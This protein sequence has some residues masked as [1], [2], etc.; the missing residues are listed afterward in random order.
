[1]KNNKNFSGEEV[2]ELKKG[3]TFLLAPNAKC[4]GSGTG[5]DKRGVN[6]FYSQSK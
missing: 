1:L 4:P 5:Q 3:A 2:I 6:T